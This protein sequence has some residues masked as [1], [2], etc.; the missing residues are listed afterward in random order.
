MNE[1]T[2][3]MLHWLMCAKLQ[4]LPWPKEPGKFSERL[5]CRGNPFL[6]ILLAEN[7]V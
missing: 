7:L 1:V 2:G 6:D 3:Q 5:G 4:T